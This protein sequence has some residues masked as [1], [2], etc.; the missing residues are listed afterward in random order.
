MEDFES[1]PHCG[2]ELRKNAKFCPE[3]GSS[4]SD[5]WRDEEEGHADDESFDY[6]EFVE[7][8]YGST[9]ANLSTPLHWRFVA[10][11]LL[12]VFTLACF[13]MM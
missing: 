6:D 7:R 2:A 11:V 9:A 12:I 1:C 3:C 8:N 13:A 10:I 4:D 5:G